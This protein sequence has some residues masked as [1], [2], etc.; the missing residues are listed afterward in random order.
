MYFF[1]HSSKFW[2]R[3][4][5]GDAMTDKYNLDIQGSQEEGDCS[6]FTNVF[7]AAC[8]NIVLLH[9]LIWCYLSNSF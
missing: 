9:L 8:L 7:V 2:A 4:R 6:K 5:P 3:N 1:F